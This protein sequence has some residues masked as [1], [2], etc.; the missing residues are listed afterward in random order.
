MPLK[1]LIGQMAWKFVA[2]SF[3]KLEGVVRDYI[4]DLECSIL[5]NCI[6]V[7]TGAGVEN[8]NDG[9]GVGIGM[10]VNVNLDSKLDDDDDD[11]ESVMSDEDEDEE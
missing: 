4:V 9:V 6:P 2:G 1:I 11:D 5:E 7:T 8:S 3:G 10:G